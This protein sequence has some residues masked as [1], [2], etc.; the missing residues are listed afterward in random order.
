MLGKVIQLIICKGLSR[1]MT[2]W[3]MNLFPDHHE[4]LYLSVCKRKREFFW[5]TFELITLKSSLG[6]KKKANINHRF[7]FKQPWDPHL[8]HHLCLCGQAG[9][10]AGFQPLNP[11]LYRRQHFCYSLFNIASVRT[12]SIWI[13]VPLLYLNFN[14]FLLI[15]CLLLIL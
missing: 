2:S 4:F 7:T 12:G 8:R 15:S 5:V 13:T 11:N 9:K 10:E 3:L 1:R 6:R 14:P